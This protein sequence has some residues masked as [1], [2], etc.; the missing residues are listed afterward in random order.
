MCPASD[1][2]SRAT[3]LI[4]LTLNRLFEIADLLGICIS[5]FYK[6]IS[7]EELQRSFP[8]RPV[9]AG[10]ARTKPGQ[11]RAVTVTERGAFNTGW[12]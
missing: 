12:Y 1:G 8:L 7:I 3:S 6:D 10:V 4:T 2:L 11:S 5:D 9:L